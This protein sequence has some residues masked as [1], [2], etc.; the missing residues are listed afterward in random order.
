MKELRE[1]FEK[2]FEKKLKK[3]ILTVIYTGPEPLAQGI[4]ISQFW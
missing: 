2:L 4:C 3:Y 1:D